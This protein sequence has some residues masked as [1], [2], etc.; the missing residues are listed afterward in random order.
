MI[1]VTQRNG[2]IVDIHDTT[3]SKVPKLGL[4]EAQQHVAVVPAS[5]DP[6]LS[7]RR[8]A[9][10]N[11]DGT[12]DG[13]PIWPDLGKFRKCLEYFHLAISNLNIYRDRLKGGP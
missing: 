12:G 3:E 10:R 7:P 6:V 5:L 9:G 8:I 11:G 1:L 4:V 13:A 2:D